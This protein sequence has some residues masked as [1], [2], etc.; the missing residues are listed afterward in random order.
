MGKKKQNAGINPT[1][2]VI[3]FNVSR[4]TLHTTIK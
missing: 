2:L 1:L 4:L 3:I